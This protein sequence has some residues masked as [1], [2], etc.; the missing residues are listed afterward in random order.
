MLF[1]TTNTFSS[2]QEINKNP[3]TKSKKKKKK[4][5]A[6]IACELELRQQHKSKLPLML[7]VALLPHLRNNKRSN[8]SK[9]RL[10]RTTAALHGSTKSHQ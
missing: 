1:D 7:F 10:H 8:N 4:W 6:V 9:L 2:P 5:D 3:K